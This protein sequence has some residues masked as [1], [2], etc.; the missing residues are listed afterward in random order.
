MYI[1]H[2]YVLRGSHA[3]E[4]GNARAVITNTK[5]CQ[6]NVIVTR[7]Q[8]HRRCAI[9]GGVPGTDMDNGLTTVLK[10]PHSL[11]TTPAQAEQSRIAIPY[12]LA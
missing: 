3:R 4:R 2:A 1:G 5:C 8:G 11:L 10:P 9:R 7:K 6:Y 12:E